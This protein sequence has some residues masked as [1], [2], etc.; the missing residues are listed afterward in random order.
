MSQTEI[1]TEMRFGNTRKYILKL[2]FT[3]LIVCYDKSVAPQ[4]LGER[5]L[6]VRSHF[7]IKNHLKVTSILLEKISSVFK[8]QSVYLLYTWNLELL[9]QEAIL[10]FVSLFLFLEYM[11]KRNP[12][13]HL[14]GLYYMCPL[15]RFLIR[16]TPC[17]NDLKEVSENR[18]ILYS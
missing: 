1:N 2:L 12:F 3:E 6:S 9:H 5:G 11:L 18:L 14:L 10:T 8:V 16:C 17:R 15:L 13:L 7:G 4:L